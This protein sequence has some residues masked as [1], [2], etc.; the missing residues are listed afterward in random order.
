MTESD[1]KYLPGH[2]LQ[3]QYQYVEYRSYYLPSYRIKA[4]MNTA[5]AAA[6]TPLL[7]TYLMKDKMTLPL[8]EQILAHATAWKDLFGHG[9]FPTQIEW[10]AYALRVR[11]W[12]AQDLPPRLS[13][14]PLAL[15]MVLLV[16]FCACIWILPG[17]IDVI[18]SHR[19]LKLYTPELKNDGP[20]VSA[21]FS[22]VVSYAARLLLGARR[23]SR[24]PLIALFPDTS[25]GSCWPMK[26][27]QGSLTII[28]SQPVFVEA[29]RP[30]HP[31]W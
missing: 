13:W 10:P 7:K 29:L 5:I 27:S 18:A 31:S 16:I 20:L 24:T 14:A 28:L 8:T 17:T 25:F 21:T 1:S 23:P 3:T 19:H 4:T 11:Q 9:S 6:T 12:R 30:D 2:R 22:S 26:G 15:F